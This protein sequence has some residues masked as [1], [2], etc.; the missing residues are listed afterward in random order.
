MRT[1]RGDSRIR[2]ENRD[3]LTGHGSRIAIRC[4][5]Q[6]L[7]FAE[8][9]AS[10]ARLAAGLL[11]AG[12]APGDRVGLFMPNCPELVIAYLACFSAGLLAVPLN[13]RYRAPEVAYAMERSGAEL[14]IVHRDLAAEAAG[15]AVRR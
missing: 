5:E 12:M 10:S 8:L 13:T 9:E 6:V 2:C 14:L 15:A 1:G 4:G 3:V 7:S 11:D